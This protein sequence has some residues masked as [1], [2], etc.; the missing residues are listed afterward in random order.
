ML[1]LANEACTNI[2]LVPTT[3][4]WNA[5]SL[6]T[7]YSLPPPHPPQEKWRWIMYSV[8]RHFIENDDKKVLWH[9]TAKW[10]NP[11]QPNPNWLNPTN[12][13]TSGKDSVTLLL[14]GIIKWFLFLYG[15][16]YKWEPGS[17]KCVYSVMP[18][19]NMIHLLYWRERSGEQAR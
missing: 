15:Y 6:R 10:T 7:A 13:I 19:K 3:F 18:L 4:M 17:V 1:W 12:R 9:S 16:Q 8:T 11:K 14:A 2:T 5:L